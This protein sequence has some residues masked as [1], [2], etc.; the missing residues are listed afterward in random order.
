MKLAVVGTGL[1]GASV[2]LAAKRAGSSG[3]PAS[4]PTRPRP[5]PPSSGAQSTRS[6]SSTTCWPTP[7]SR[8][9]PRRSPCCPA[10]V[11][12]VL[13]RAGDRTTVTDVGSTKDWSAG[14]PSGS[15]AAI[16][17]AAARRRG[18]AHA[19]AELFDGATWFLTPTAGTDPERYRLV[20]GFVA[21]LGAVPVAID[22]RGARPARRADEPPAARARQPARQPG[23]RRD[24]SRATTR[25]P[26]PA[27]R[28]AT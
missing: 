27:A 10:L 14:F 7:T 11:E 6:P 8:S 24:G 15:S 21:S 12:D 13:A 20:H 19:T 3:S 23:R 16:R 22:P 28:C 18:A 9:S 1:M 25:S 2:G 5:R 17:S 26:P 4:T